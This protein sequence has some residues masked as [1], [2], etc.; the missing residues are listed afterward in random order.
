MKRLL[1]IV[2]I[3]VTLTPRAQYKRIE[4]DT[5]YTTLWGDTMWVYLRTDF[6][7]DLARK[8]RLCYRDID[9]TAFFHKDSIWN[10]YGLMPPQGTDSI[11]YF[12]WPWK[13]H[14]PRPW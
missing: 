7:G 11:P 3:L 1:T 10:F 6:F 13:Y 4:R 5:M 9:L 8:P 14:V 12:R 2:L